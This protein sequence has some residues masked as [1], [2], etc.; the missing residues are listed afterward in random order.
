MLQKSILPG[1]SL[2]TIEPLHDL[3]EALC[4]NCLRRDWYIL[5]EGD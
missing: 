5:P 1:A 2:R 3:P 4:A